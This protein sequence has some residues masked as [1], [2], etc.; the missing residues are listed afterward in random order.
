[1]IYAQH[2]FAEN[3]ASADGR[4]DE[5]MKEQIVIDELARLITT[6]K[7]D[8][9]KLLRDNG[10]NATFNDTTDRIT[11]LTLM[12]ISQNDNFILDL[13]KLI[14]DNHKK[15]E[16]DSDYSLSASGLMEK[17]YIS[18]DSSKGLAAAIKKIGRIRKKNKFGRAKLY[19]NADD[20]LRSRVKLADAKIN[21]K[22]FPKWAKWTL[23]ALGVSA[24]V[25]ASIII[26]RK[27][28]KNSIEPFVEPINS[29]S[30]IENDDNEIYE[31]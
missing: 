3:F 2:N 28:N 21:T 17:E 11:E 13:K 22:Q 10:I 7:N 26:V 29:A 31:E 18:R 25:V 19:A 24:L 15:I 14:L 23:I 9:V 20:L 12:L 5:F 6:R 4:K 8:V 16:G 30:T 27:F 1:M